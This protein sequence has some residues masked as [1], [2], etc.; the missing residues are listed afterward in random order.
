MHQ[1]VQPK[2]KRTGKKL[3]K[4]MCLLRPIHLQKKNN[5]VRKTL[6]LTKLLRR[7]LNKI[8][9]RKIKKKKKIYRINSLKRKKICKSNDKMLKDNKNQ[10][11]RKIL[12]RKVRY[13][14]KQTLKREKSK[15][16]RPML[17]RINMKQIFNLMTKILI[18]HVPQMK[19][20]GML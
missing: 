15:I 9:T 7:I 5:Q 18:Y 11:F 8:R 16:Q 6:R 17:R 12:R 10:K 19:S 2:S 1:K 3:L 13:K 14:K 4:K 20:K